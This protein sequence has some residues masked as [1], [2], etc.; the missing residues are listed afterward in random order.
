MHVSSKEVRVR[1]KSH[2]TKKTEMLRLKPNQFIERILSHIAIPKKQQYHFVGLYH[3]RCRERL[4]K[5]RQYLGQERIKDIS[6]LLWREYA[7]SKGQVPCCDECGGKVTVL[8]RFRVINGE[9]I[10]SSKM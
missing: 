4:N 7:E 6:P 3:N 8:A 2:Q 1:Y 10:F 5:A 9:F